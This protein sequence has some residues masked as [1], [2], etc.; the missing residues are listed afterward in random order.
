MPF[1]KHFAFAL[2]TL[3]SVSIL[4]SDPAAEKADS[5]PVSE[6]IKAALAPTD[7]QPFAPSYA[8]T[9]LGRD[10]KVTDWEDPQ[11]CAGCHPRQYKGWKGSMHANAFKDPIFQAE[12][13]L[14]EKALGSNISNLCGGC[15]SPAGMLSQTIEFDKN[16]GKHGGFT[17][18]GVAN[19]GVFCD[20]CHT[21]SGTNL[22]NTSQLEHGN[23]SYIASPGKIK[24]GPLKDAKSPYHE[25]AYSEHHTK[26]EFCGNCH[27]IFNP[28]NNFPV[29][30]TY[31]EWKYS[32]YAQND[33][34]CQDCHMVPVETA[35]RVADELTPARK[36]KDAGLGG[37]AGMGAPGERALVHD[38][39]FVGGNAVVT[40][41]MGDTASKEHA[42]IAKKRLQNVVE[43]EGFVKQL[44]GSLHQLKVKVTNA[45]AGHDI[46][47]SLTFIRE[48]WL[49]ISIKDDKGN[50]IYRSGWMDEHN[51]IEPNATV[52]KAHAVDKD[53]KVA[54]Y[55][56]TVARFEERNTI[57]PKGH[58]W[59]KY[60]F[61]VPEDSKSIKISAKL[62]YRSFSQ[63]FVDHLLGEGKLDVPVIEMKHIELD[64]P[65]N[66]EVAAK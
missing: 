48:I 21:I 51:E 9:D 13:A 41:A 3:Y 39:A 53:G 22:H 10:L 42:E 40:E 55:I 37:F 18:P 66:T 54:E 33:V 36:L 45:R 14:A 62:N 2:L 50:E 58:R 15:H 63:H 49:E 6:A 31:D 8:T 61:N 30:R 1:L 60:A 46:P 25:T 43:L 11:V 12:W 23:G 29:E 64:V 7:K 32:V 19:E 17:A 20:V 59:G 28:I 27:N 38:H 35:M 44:K 56:W 47:T 52:F 34:Q 65:V 26:S 5:K 57:P 4:A 24:R 16:L